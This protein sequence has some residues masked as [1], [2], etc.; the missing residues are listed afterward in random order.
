M[1]LS[2]YGIEVG[3]GKQEQFD[4]SKIFTDEGKIITD[5]EQ[6]VSEEEAN[7]PLPIYDI[8]LAGVE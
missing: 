5:F 8:I 6:V 7:K 2:F 4:F 1:N 3:I